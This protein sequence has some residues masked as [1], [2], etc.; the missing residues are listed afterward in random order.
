[1]RKEVNR[2]GGPST[3]KGL[4]WKKYTTIFL[5]KSSRPLVLNYLKSYDWI[6]SA[7]M[8]FHASGIIVIFYDYMDNKYEKFFY[9]LQF[10]VKEL[11]VGANGYKVS[12][13]L[14]ATGSTLFLKKIFQNQK[15][16]N[17]F[18]VKKGKIIPVNDTS[19]I[20]PSAKRKNT[21]YFDK[22]ALI[23]FIKKNLS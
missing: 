22:E 17:E 8:S 14:K 10:K 9:F 3:N 5:T 2:D 16:E 23:D 21:G 4:V 12:L 18:R 19:P 13:P 1:M 6:V 7:K 15:A 20:L 11:K